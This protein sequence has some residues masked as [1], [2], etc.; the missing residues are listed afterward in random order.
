FPAFDADQRRGVAQLAQ[1]VR[2]LFG[3][4][5]AV[6]EKLE[7]AVSMRREQVQ[8]LRVHERLAAQN[9]EEG[10]PVLFG[11]GDG[12]IQ[13]V[14]IDGVLLLDIYPAALAAKVAGVDDRE[15]E[16]RRKIVAAFDAPL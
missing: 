5:L 10:V 4:E 6:G 8:Q 15:I 9:P 16:K 12:A 11:V 1:P 3:D 7:V 14:Q 13:A 2:D